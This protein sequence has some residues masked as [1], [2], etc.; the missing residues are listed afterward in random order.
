MC[1]HLFIIFEFSRTL[2]YFCCLSTAFF[3]CVLFHFTQMFNNFIIVFFTI[4]VSYAI[5]YTIGFTF[6]YFKS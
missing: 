4:A 3:V 2:S 6:T 1:L 5:G